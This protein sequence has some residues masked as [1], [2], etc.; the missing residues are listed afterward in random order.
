MKSTMSREEVLAVVRGF[1]LD[2]AADVASYALDETN[3]SA[4]LLI[5]EDMEPV[6]DDVFYQKLA[7]KIQ[8]AEGCEE[9]ENVFKTA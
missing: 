5:A 7:A 3:V 8:A 4:L 6:L 2:G 1:V 9:W